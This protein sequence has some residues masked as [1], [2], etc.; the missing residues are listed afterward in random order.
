M[1]LKK[2]KRDIPSSWSFHRLEESHYIELTLQVGGGGRGLYKDANTRIE[3]SLGTFI[4]LPATV[5]I[6]IPYNF[7][8]LIANN[9]CLL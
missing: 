9:P 7:S 3:G 8:V 6:N 5:I 1:L 2:K 4:S